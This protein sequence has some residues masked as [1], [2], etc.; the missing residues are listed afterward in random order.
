MLRTWHVEFRAFQLDTVPESKIIV[1]NERAWVSMISYV[2]KE[3]KI[4]ILKRKKTWELFRICLLNSTAN[5]AQF[6]GVYLSGHVPEI[7]AEVE[8]VKI[9]K[10][11][12]SCWA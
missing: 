8:V 6:Q 10:P 1:K 9:K 5:P 7:Q 4:R 3:I 12:F 11:D 2:K